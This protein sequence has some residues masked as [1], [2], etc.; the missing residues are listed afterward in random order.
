MPEITVICV[1]QNGLDLL[2]LAVESLYLHN[3]DC[4]FLL[5][6]WDN[7]SADGT[8]D[9]LRD[10][11]DRLWVKSGPMGHHH[12]IPLDRMVAAVETPYVLTLDNDVVFRGPVLG[13]MLR[14]LRDTGAFACGP[15]QRCDMGTVEHRGV[16][17]VG[18]PRVD[19]CCA[20]FRTPE[21]QRLTAHISF[22]PAESVNTG[23]FYDTGA[24]ITA[25]AHG[26]GLRTVELPWVWERFTHFGCMTWAGQA[27][28][29][30]SSRTAVDGKMTVVR[31]L[32]SSTYAD[33]A[34]DTEVVIARFREDLSWAARLP[35]KRVYDKSGVPGAAGEPLPNVGREAHTYAEHVARH[36]DALP[37]VTVFTQGHPFDHAPDFFNEL[38]TPPALFK[39]F[40]PHRMTTGPDGDPSHRLPTA[41]FY[42]RVTGR[43][44]PDAGTTFSPGAVFAAHRSALHRYPR[45]WWRR[46]ADVLAEP[47]A[48]A[49]APWVM[50]RLWR[51]ILADPGL[52]HFYH[53]IPG[54][55]SGH[56]VYED[57]VAAAPDGAHF[58]EV[59]CWAGCSAAFMATAIRN[60]GKRIRFDAVDTWKGS[61]NPAEA[62]MKEQIAALGGS[63]RP[64]FERN[65]ARAAGF[66]NPVES[67]SAAAA[68]GYPDGSLD[69]VYVD[70]S[71]ERAA[72]LRDLR[73]WFPKVKPGGWIG[74]DD[75]SGAHPGVPDAVN[76]F[77]GYNTNVWGNQWLAQKPPA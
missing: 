40:G 32:L 77:F 45:A 9:W 72:V 16:T 5:W 17:L 47:D 1:T 44:Y 28:Q 22:S 69:F 67:D 36:Y 42:T 56:R 68:D 11:C 15:S 33:L 35:R 63:M 27:P 55:F 60:S 41:E 71:H 21:L 25:A 43:P 50:E 53:T 2:R 6:V 26:A 34:A 52:P 7:D 62:F 70:A 74:G 66:V 31:D 20:L 12:G 51:L 18:Q 48:Q 59:G 30:T 14:A 76:A 73:A 46:L 10:R 24:L 3:P 58:V 8:R 37:A 13:D 19:P 39:A 61:D 29:G 4:R 49:H 38:K 65:V 23:R 54:W 57:R 75:F 64:T